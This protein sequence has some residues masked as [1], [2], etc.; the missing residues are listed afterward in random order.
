MVRLDTSVK[1]YRLEDGVKIPTAV[2]LISG[3]TFVKHSRSMPWKHSRSAAEGVHV[4]VEALPEGF[5]DN[6][7]ADDEWFRGVWVPLE[8]DAPE[9]E[10]Q[11]PVEVEAHHATPTPRVTKTRAAT[12]KKKK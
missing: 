10:T 12:K 7:H 11:I 2:D 6:S 9:D 1:S 3:E 5:H 4:D 8:D